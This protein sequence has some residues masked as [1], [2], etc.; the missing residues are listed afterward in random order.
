MKATPAQRFAKIFALF[1]AGATP[2]ERAAAERK[3]DAWLR[4]HSKTRGDIPA[5]L[6]QAVADDAAS[7]PPPPPPP[8][9]RTT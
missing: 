2:D 3:L 1:M 5:V 9:P 4:Q 7:A 6:A 8:D